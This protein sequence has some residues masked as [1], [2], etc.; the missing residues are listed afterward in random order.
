MKKAFILIL[1]TII[2][3]ATYAQEKKNI[4]IRAIGQTTLAGHPRP[5]R[6]ENDRNLSIVKWPDTEYQE[7]HDT[8]GIV[9]NVPTINDNELSFPW[10]DY[11]GFTPMTWKLVDEGKN[12]VLHC[13][14]KMPSDIVTNFWLGS[15]ETVLLDQET[16][17]IYQ[18]KATVPA[19]CYNK[20]FSIESKK[21]SVLDFQI[22]YNRLP[23]KAR[24]LKVYGLPE[25]KMR[26]TDIQRD[27][28][29]TMPLGSPDYDQVPKF[30]LPKLVKDSLNYDRNVNQ[31]WAVYKDVHTIKPVE[32]GTLALWRTKDAT[33]LAMATEQNWY[34]E[35]WGY[36]GNSVLMD[37]IGHR[38][39]CKGLVGFQNDRLFWVEGYPGDYFAIVLI[40]EPIP[41]DLDTFSYIEPEGEPINMWG[42]NWSGEVRSD[43][44]VSELRQ[45]QK[46]FNYHKRI[47]VK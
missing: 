41:L 10:D 28:V 8:I 33:Y 43:L 27:M 39:K 29:T 6:Y 24:K 4:R 23:D 46:L 31:S 11:R 34:R 14:M 45:N 40:F 37:D 2:C 15:G 21:D 9:K 47:V 32:D 26:G 12:T 44:K 38:Y 19:E 17:I 5:T 42:A 20:V 22:V 7:W 1:L 35:W 13:Y 36:G 3:I 18:P 25:W 16:G 30:H